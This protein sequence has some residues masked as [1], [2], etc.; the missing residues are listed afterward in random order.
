MTRTY[1]HAHTRR[2][3]KGQNE[4]ER[5]EKKRMWTRIGFLRKA[6]NYYTKKK[7]KKNKFNDLIIQRY[8]GISFLGFHLLLDH[9]A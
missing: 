9:T 8:Q 7:K 5:R 4:N 6:E 1:T 3:I 2:E